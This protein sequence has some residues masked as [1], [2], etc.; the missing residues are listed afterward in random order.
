VPI[1]V[2][3]PD[4]RKN[5]PLGKVARRLWRFMGPHQRIYFAGLTLGVLD[6]ACQTLIPMVFRGVL[7]SL[8]RGQ[9]T[10]VD[11]G[12]WLTLAGGVGLAFL[13][14]PIAYFFHRFLI[15]AMARMT[16][17]MRTRLYYHVQRLSADFFQGRKVGEINQRL[18]N[19]V[20]TLT[21]AGETTMYFVWLLFRVIW[22][23]TAMIYIDVRLTGLFV[24][25]MA[26]LGLWTR[27]Y[28]PKI[29]EMHRSV[30]DKLGQTSATITEYVGLNDLI[31]SY[32][33]EE[34]AEARVA[35][36]TDEIRE[37][38]E[39]LARWQFLYAD[40]TQVLLLFLAPF[41][42]LF[43][44]AWMITAGHLRV[45]DLVAFYAYWMMIGASVNGIIN[46]F[47]RVFAGLASADRVFELFD[48]KPLVTDAPHAHDL[49][50]VRGRI[51]F[52][53]VSFYYP[54]RADQRVLDRVRFEVP[55][56]QRLAIVGPS[57]AGKST[58]LQ[59]IL[60]FYDPHEGRVTIDG[61]DLRD[62]TQRS[63]RRNVGMVMQES[64][65]FSGTIADNLRLGRAEATEDEMREALASADLLE[66]VDSQRD[67][68]YTL[69]GERG[70]SLSGGQKQR[71][72]IA[73]VFLKDP[74]VLLFDEATSSLDSLAEKQVQA[75]MGRLMTGRTTV[76]VAHRI[77]TVRNADRI[78]LLDE[79]RIRATGR[80]EELLARDRLY[81]E[82]CAHQHVAPVPEE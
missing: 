12:F 3:I 22:S 39:R 24:V 11:T 44:G 18:N 38:Q 65:F 5:V 30:R 75:A 51:A 81:Q 53:D 82:L 45:G 34:T 20:D 32:T 79:G 78:L 17:E 21:L 72:S 25:L 26:G 31:K 35:K 19:D 9:G 59:L 42:L 61:N 14:F 56:G 70:A 57:G 1:R 68:L 71:L 64:V 80:H 46:T 50:E 15:V 33:G 41:T 4:E 49:G 6:A 43:V 66:F 55:A 63:L 48:E 28:M 23:L 40:I 60:R 10:H 37:E 76:I 27:S 8:E 69:L 67:G 58:I 7:N 74:P 54:A 77:A 73:R 29:R 16:Q 47:T 62:L 13:F 52:E 36:S 2:V